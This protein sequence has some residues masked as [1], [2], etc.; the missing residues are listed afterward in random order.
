LAVQITNKGSEKIVIDIGKIEKI[1]RC[2]I[3]DGRKKLGEI[4]IV[5]TSD[6]EI[7]EINQKYLQ[8]NYLTDI[9]TFDYNT[10]S[11]VNGD[12]FISC[13]TV[14]RNA[15]SYRQNF[16]KELLR[17]IIHGVLHLLGYD[18]KSEKE[19]TYM[20]SLEDIYLKKAARI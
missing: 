2:I 11:N 5:I 1:I 16:K 14:K 6:N 17:V 12:L 15:I 10:K 9:I 8:H 4:D 3:D 13:E 19:R 7:L 18:D 20:R